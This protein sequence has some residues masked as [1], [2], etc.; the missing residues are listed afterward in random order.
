M[1]TYDVRI[2]WLETGT[3][4]AAMLGEDVT[5][6]VE[7]ATPAVACRE[8]AEDAVYHSEERFCTGRYDVVAE[9]VD[10]VASYRIG[11]DEETAERMRR[12]DA[13]E[14]N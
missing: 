3:R 11:P 5:V 7:A 1:A 10:G 14:S 2:T 6:A 8:T 4:N 12:E 9:H 13:A